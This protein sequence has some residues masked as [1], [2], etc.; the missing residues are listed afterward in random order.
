MEKLSGGGRGGVGSGDDLVDNVGRWIQT[1]NYDKILA[2]A[3]LRSQG[4]TDKIFTREVVEYKIDDM[5]LLS[6]MLWVMVR[7]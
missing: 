7:V 2:L 1:L 6:R 5:F 4:I 3:K